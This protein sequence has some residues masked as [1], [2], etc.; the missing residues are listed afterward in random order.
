MPG[1]PGS[2]RDTLAG[3]LRLIGAAA[4]VLALAPLYAILTADNPTVLPAARPWLVGLTLLG[5]VSFYV[6]HRLSHI[7]PLEDWLLAPPRANPPDSPPHADQTGV[8]TDGPSS[9]Q[10]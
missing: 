1:T 5:A 3:L 7:P 9:L 8:G 6:A 2:W 10:P 4:L